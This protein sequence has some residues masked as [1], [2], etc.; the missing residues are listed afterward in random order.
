MIIIRT[1][2]ET[3]MD[4][5]R[6]PLNW[7]IS[8]PGDVKTFKACANVVRNIHNSKYVRQ[9]QE[10]RRADE[11]CALTLHIQLDCAGLLLATPEGGSTC[12]AFDTVST[13]NQESDRGCHL[14]DTLCC[15]GVRVFTGEVRDTPC[16]YWRM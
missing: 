10:I 11:F 12:Q 3:G 7:Y 16:E 1:T 2:A 14:P 13:F 5:G 4:T 15:Q 8:D 6:E 9:L